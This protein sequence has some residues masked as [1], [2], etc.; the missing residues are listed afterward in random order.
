MMAP[1]AAPLWMIPCTSARSRA[2]YHS[3][4][5]LKAAMKLPDSPMPSRNRSAPS[6]Q[7]PRAKAWAMLASDHQI[8]NRL[9]EFRVPQRST[10]YPEP[11]YITV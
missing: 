8:M 4:T 2:G 6:D 1:I 9:S 10:R 3:L 11:T 5:T 7:A